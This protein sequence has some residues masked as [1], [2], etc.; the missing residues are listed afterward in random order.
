[1]GRTTALGPCPWEA[2]GWVPW[3]CG[4]S[5]FL[6]RW[7][8]APYS[9]VGG[10]V[11]GLPCPSHGAEWTQDLHGLF[12]NP[13]QGKTVHC[14][15]WPDGVTGFAL[16]VERAT[17]QFSTQGPL[18]S[19]PQSRLLRFPGAPKG[20]PARQGHGLYSAGVEL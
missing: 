11:K 16:Q 1:M 3:L 7:Y 5:S 18:Y 8:W 4:F 10:A 13:N 14:V 12:G 20:F 6:A 17:G 15:P 2:V 9:V 19:E